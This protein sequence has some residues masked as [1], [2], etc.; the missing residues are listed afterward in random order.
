MLDVSSRNPSILEISS[1]GPEVL[2]FIFLKH[3]GLWALSPRNPGFVELV[4]LETEDF[5]V[6][7]SEK[8]RFPDVGE[9]LYCLAD[10]LCTSGVWSNIALRTRTALPVCFYFF[11]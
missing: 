6:D 4:L 9:L 11:R 8:W 3:G 5:G 1:L 7:P 2:K 10:A